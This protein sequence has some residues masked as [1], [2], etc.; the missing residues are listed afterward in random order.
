MFTIIDVI[1]PT[2]SSYR[3]LPAIDTKN[4]PNLQGGSEIKEL[5]IGFRQDLSGHGVRGVGFWFGV[6]FELV[7]CI[8]FGFDPRHKTKVIMCFLEF[9]LVY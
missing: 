2:C 8:L 6:L 7:W 5:T 1:D 4:P 9:G 3:F